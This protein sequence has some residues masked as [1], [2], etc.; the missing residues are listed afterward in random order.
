[1]HAK[2]KEMW[3]GGQGE[4]KGEVGKEGGKGKSGNQKRDWERGCTQNQ[5]N[6]VRVQLTIS[7]TQMEK[8]NNKW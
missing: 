3:G 6:Q 8:S 4:L 1:V 2:S 7:T 5:R